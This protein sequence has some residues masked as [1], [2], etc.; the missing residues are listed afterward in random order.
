MIKR[1]WIAEKPSAARVL[2][3]G[4]CAAYKLTIVNRDTSAKDGYI[5][6]SDGD[7]VAPQIGHLI[8]PK[9]LSPEHKAAKAET[10]FSF[11]PIVVKDFEYEPRYEMS[12]TG[13]IRMS[14][15]R[16]VP[17]RQYSVMVNLIRSAKEIVNAGDID[18]EGQLITDE[19]LIH[20]GID[21]EG[22][23]KPIW[24]F[25]L[26]SEL[27]ND[28]RDQLINLRV[29]EKNSDKKWVWKRHAALARAHSDAAVGFNGSMA[30][31]AASG[32][33]RAS[34]GRVQTPVLCLIVDRE[35][36]IK[37][38]KPKPVYVPRVVLADGTEMVFHKRAEAI[39]QPGF[40]EEGRIIDEGVA[41]RICSLISNGMGGKVTAAKRI[42]GSEA[43]PLPFTGTILYSTVSKRTGLTPS[44]VEAAATSLKDKHKAISYI[45]T[46]C[47]F[48]PTSLLAKAHDTMA[49]LSRIYPQHAGGANLELRSAAWNDDKVTEHSGIV[50]T[51]ILPVNASPEEKAVYDAVVKRYVAQFYP[52]HEFATSQLAAMFGQDEFRATK[53]ETVRM[54]WKEIEGH[55]EQGGPQSSTTDEDAASEQDALVEAN[56][57]RD[58]R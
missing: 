55:L 56:V 20:L 31:Q 44:Q 30:Y 4:I 36:Q 50:P 57:E 48:L 26:V 23:D 3:A 38:F 58:T 2:A 7:V 13:E 16:P 18:K 43:P 42:N 15:G 11:L 14:Q 27:E 54:G 45:G 47:R 22:R 49:A 37:H 39:G 8:Q 53:R 40:D 41:R 46:D 51:G 33:R 28:V 52:A 10:F 24:R 29:M 34:V 5:K 21:P 1:L 9:F 32:Y 25:P 12:K 17:I 35:E 19:L 6:L